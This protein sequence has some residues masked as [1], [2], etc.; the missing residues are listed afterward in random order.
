MLSKEAF[1][2]DQRSMYGLDADF[3]S[4]ILEYLRANGLTD[5]WSRRYWA[6]HWQHPSLEMGFEMLHRDIL[7]KEQLYGMFKLHEYPPF[8]R[9]KLV[10]LSYNP[11]GRVDIR[12]I[13]KLKNKSR[14]WLEDKLKAV[15]YNEEDTKDMADFYEEYN[16]GSGRD[17]TLAQLKK[18]YEFKEISTEQFLNA[19]TGM[20]YDND[21]ATLIQHVIDKEITEKAVKEV[22][23]A[24]KT[25][26]QR[27]RVTWEDVNTRLLR[28]GVSTEKREELKS[29]WDATI[30]ESKAELTK[31]EILKAFTF[32]IISTSET[33][34]YLRDFGY[35]DKQIEIL[36]HTILTDKHGFPMYQL[37]DDEWLR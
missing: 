6:A 33:V 27:G 28:L 12:R 4:E 11:I 8:W 10:A 31:E 21:E 37:K 22:I 2:P 25:Q 9:D 7:T 26:Y 15:G 36:I 23:R 5:D 24:Y 13:H 18:A 20:G 34:S 19:L 17:L 3:P 29:T 16:K 14:A 30:V 1:E 32:K 35:D